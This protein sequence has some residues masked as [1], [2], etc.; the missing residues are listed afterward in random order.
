M[1]SKYRIR[2]LENQSV[3]AID[4]AKFVN[5]PY[6]F[7]RFYIQDEKVAKK[8]IGN[9]KD[10]INGKILGKMDWEKV[11][12]HNLLA[13]LPATENTDN[14]ETL[15]LYLNYDASSVIPR[16][17]K[18]GITADNIA[19]NLEILKCI[20]DKDIVENRKQNL[21][22][23]LTGAKTM[24]YSGIREFAHILRDINAE[25]RI[26]YINKKSNDQ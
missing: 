22:I 19:I 16:N 9:I 7:P 2:N 21:L 24:W 6:Q 5:V 14:T 10:S 1:G 18:G 15:L 26:G 20:N 23:M 13:F 11:P 8:L 25:K 17:A 3:I 12:A 4:N